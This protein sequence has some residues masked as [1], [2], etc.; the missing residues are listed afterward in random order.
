M[1]TIQTSLLLGCMLLIMSFFSCDDDSNDNPNNGPQTFEL[2][3]FAEGGVVFY[4]D[5]S[6]EHGLVCAILDQSDAAEWC[7]SV[8]EIDGADGTAIGTGSQNT[9]DILSGC[10]SN[11]S[12]AALCSNLSF[13]GFNDW[14]LPSRD[15][16][17]AIYQNKGIINSTAA[18]NGG[19]A[20]ADETY[21]TS[22]ELDIGSKTS[23]ETVSMESGVSGSLTKFGTA[24]V[25][26]VREF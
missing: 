20:L 7:S 3:D 18:S 24:Y 5:N 2:G 8:D 12:A 9:T 25:R 19:S 10:A 14:F 17:K 15:E 11:T 1:K 22:T 4:L 21:W 23:A 16:L 6:K 13:N 26:A